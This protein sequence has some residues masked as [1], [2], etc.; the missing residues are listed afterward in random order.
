MAF[1]DWPNELAIYLKWNRCSIFNFNKKICNSFS[2]ICWLYNNIQ[3]YFGLFSFN[4][5][6]Y[7]L[8]KWLFQAL[9]LC[10]NI[11][12]KST[13]ILAFKSE[14]VFNLTFTSFFQL[15]LLLIFIIYKWIALELAICWLDLNF[16]WI[17]LSS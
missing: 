9:T 17:S 4:Y 8:V 3:Y 7:N 6:I 5:S 11:N 12:F 2:S 1:N 13:S 15:Y 16:A 14:C 10:L